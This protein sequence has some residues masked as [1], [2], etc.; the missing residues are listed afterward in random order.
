MSE[1]YITVSNLFNIAIEFF[2][3]SMLMIAIP[4]LG[5]MYLIK[6]VRSL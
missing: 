2:S 3:D 6:V 4:F 1:I 5:G